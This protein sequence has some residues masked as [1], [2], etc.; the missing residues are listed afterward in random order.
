MGHPCLPLCPSAAG[1]ALFTCF[2]AERILDFQRAHDKTPLSK[3]AFSSSGGRLAAR[4]CSQSNTIIPGCL[5]SKNDGAQT[6]DVLLS[7]SCA[8]QGAAARNR[9]A[10]KGSLTTE[11]TP[12][13]HRALFKQHMSFTQREITSQ[14]GK[15]KM[16]VST[17][18]VS[19]QQKSLPNTVSL[20][21]PS[22][23]LFDRSFQMCAMTTENPRVWVPTL[24]LLFVYIS[25]RCS[26]RKLLH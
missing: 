12:G 6:P 23:C 5:H 17:V 3:S 22:H 26:F 4:P 8:S 18:Y 20:F 16:R 13:H 1:R 14:G 19:K 21:W 24:P 2:L 15:L 7:P 10:L 9:Y 25:P 11:C